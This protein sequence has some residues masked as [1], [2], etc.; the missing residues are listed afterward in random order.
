AVAAAS[1]ASRDFS[2]IGGLGEL[3]ESSSEASKLSSKSAKEW[4]NR[5]KKR[6]QRDHMEGNHRIEG[7]RFP[8]SESEDSVKR[9]SFLFS[10]DGNRL[11][12]DKKLCSPHQSLLSIRGSLFSPRRNS[13]TSIF[14]FRGRA[15]DVGSENDFADDEHS[16]FEDSESRRDSLFVPHRPGERRNSNGTTTETEVRKRRLSSYQISMEMLEDSSGRQR[17]MS[18]ASILTNTME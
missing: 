16:T 15:K 11:T 12:G 1:A 10:L 2:G 3:L 13:K 5:R 4:R 17:A 7:D 9:R 14:S 8:K 18:I 6:R